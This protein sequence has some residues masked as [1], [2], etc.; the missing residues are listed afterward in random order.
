MDRILIE[1]LEVRYCVGVPDEERAHPQRLTLTIE[2][3]HPC[4]PAAASDDL[5]KTINYFAVC[6]RLLRLGEGGRSWR[7]LEALAEEIAAVILGEF[8]AEGVTVEVRKFIIPE[9]RHVAVRVSR[10]A[11]KRASV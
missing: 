11:G 8:G 9:A 1:E 10:R 3:E 6:Q 7:L 4:G 2:M 5:G